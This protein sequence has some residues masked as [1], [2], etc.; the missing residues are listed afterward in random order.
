ML[1][2][3]SLIC[4]QCALPYKKKTGVSR[5]QRHR[6]AHKCI[7]WTCNLKQSERM[8]VFCGQII[9]AQC[10]SRV[11]KRN[12]L[13]VMLICKIHHMILTWLGSYLRLNW[14]TLSRW[15]S[16]MRLSWLIWLQLWNSSTPNRLIYKIRL[17]NWT[18][19]STSWRE[20][21]KW[22]RESWVKWESV[23][24]VST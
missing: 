6:C 13:Q 4:T 24:K 9:L 3:L 15:L 18:S 1:I 19:K 12:R 16:H 7:C 5:L 20:T 11:H 22:K 23:Q 14:K 10:K 21:K 2:G 17:W 8:S